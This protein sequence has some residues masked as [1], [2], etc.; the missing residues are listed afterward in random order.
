MGTKGFFKYIILNSGKRCNNNPGGYT[1]TD[2]TRNSCGTSSRSSAIY[3]TCGKLLTGS[4][5]PTFFLNTK[6]RVYVLFQKIVFYFLWLSSNYGQNFY[7]F[8][9]NQNFGLGCSFSKNNNS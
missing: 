7:Q 3:D 2:N 6:A 4:S 8:F 5:F 1:C 9:L